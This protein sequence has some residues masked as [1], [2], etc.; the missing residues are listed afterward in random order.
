MAQNH[1]LELALTAA[2][3]EQTNETAEEPVRQ[4]G[5]QDAQSEPPRPSSPPAHRHR[6]I[7]FLYPTPMREV[8]EAVRTHRIAKDTSTAAILSRH[9]TGLNGVYGPGSGKASA[10]FGSPPGPYLSRSCEYE[11]VIGRTRSVLLWEECFS[12]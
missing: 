2:A 1:D 5:Q 6:R 4:T 8:C 10:A 11:L 3:G 7:E 12:E 9:S